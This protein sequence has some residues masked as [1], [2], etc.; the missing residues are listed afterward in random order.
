MTR[1]SREDRQIVWA[2]AEP[3]T[4]SVIAVFSGRVGSGPG[5]LSELALAASMS[6]AFL[7]VHAADVRIQ[8]GRIG[9]RAIRSQIIDE[10]QKPESMLIVNSVITGLNGYAGNNPA[11]EQGPYWSSQER[12]I[13]TNGSYEDASGILE[14]MSTTVAQYIKS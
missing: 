7:D 11:S 2:D 9:L 14:D 13:I 5:E 10:L 8:L 12:H 1:H 4:R 6:E 3:L